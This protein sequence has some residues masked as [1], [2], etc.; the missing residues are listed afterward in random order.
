M[1]DI[2]KMAEEAK[3]ETGKLFEDRNRRGR[4][5]LQDFYKRAEEESGRTT[6]ELF[7]NYHGF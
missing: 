4:A 6:G 3:L 2:S 1:A 5:E 7:R